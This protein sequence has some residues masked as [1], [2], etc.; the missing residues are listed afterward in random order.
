MVNTNSHFFIVFGM[1]VNNFAVRRREVFLVI[2]SNTASTLMI[3]GFVPQMLFC[4]SRADTCTCTCTCTCTST[5]RIS[6]LT[7]RNY[8]MTT[9]RHCSRVCITG[10]TNPHILFIIKLKIHPDHPSAFQYTHTPPTYLTPNLSLSSYILYPNPTSHAHPHPFLHYPH[11][12]VA[13]PSS[14]SPHLSSSIPESTP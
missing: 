12:P 5:Q 10:L 8:I 3:N 14:F 7:L 4:V 1:S 11:S 6:Q 13:L 9:L 2:Y